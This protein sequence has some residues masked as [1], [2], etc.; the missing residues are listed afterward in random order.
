[1]QICQVVVGPLETNCY[2]V[3]DETRPEVLV[4]D[5]GAEPEAIRP[6]LSV[7]RDYLQAAF[8]AIEETHG[9]VDA[10]LR[11]ALGVTDEKRERLRR[12]LLR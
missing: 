5:P 3:K 4:V 12:N 6:L 7:R 8:D 1:M 11:D 10:Y 9:S 2:L